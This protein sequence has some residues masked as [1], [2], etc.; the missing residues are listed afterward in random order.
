MSHESSKRVVIPNVS[1]QFLEVE[2]ADSCCMNVV[3]VKI[4][5][6]SY[7]EQTDFDMSQDLLQIRA[8]VQELWRVRQQQ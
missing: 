5:K 4:S 2:F 6:I 1:F 7:I 8:P 3:E